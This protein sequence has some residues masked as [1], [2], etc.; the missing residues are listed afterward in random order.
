MDWSSVIITLIS[1]LF[2]GGVVGIFTIREQRKSLKLEN[3]A[4]EIEN[5]TKD[6]DR[7]ITLINELQDQNE[8]L[9]ARLDKKDELIQ[10]KD[11]IISDLRSK[12]DS[13]RTKCAMAEILKCENVACVDREPKLGTRKVDVDEIMSDTHV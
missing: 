4:K 9:N 7:L 5:N 10:D 1:V 13:I 2:G 12:L 3:Q 11:D 6:T 8:T